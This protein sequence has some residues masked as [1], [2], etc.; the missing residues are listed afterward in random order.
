[1]SIEWIRED[2]WPVFEGP[3]GGDGR[4][5]S[6]LVSFR[7]DLKGEIRLGWIHG[8]NRE[9]VDDEQFDAALF[10]QNTVERSVDLSAV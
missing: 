7:D 9:V 10:A 6:V 8:E 4:G 3:I 5:T 2:L 1:L